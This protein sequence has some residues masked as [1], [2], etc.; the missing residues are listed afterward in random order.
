[1]VPMAP[2]TSS[3][4]C[5]VCSVAIREIHLGLEA[6]R[7]CALF[8]KR[9]K[10]TRR[11]Y[12]CR[13]GT[14]KCV[15]RKHA[16]FSC[17]K[18]R[19]DRCIAIGMEN[20]YGIVEG[21]VREENEGQQESILD[22]IQE[23]Y[24]RLMKRII[25]AER[26]IA[27]IHKLPRANTD[28]ELY[29]TTAKFYYDTYPITLHE[30]CN[31]VKCIIPA[32]EHFSEDIK[33]GI[34]KSLL[35]KFY[36]L[37]TCFRT[38]KI[39]LKTG[40]CMATAISCFDID[41]SDQWMD[42]S[43]ALGRNKSLWSSLEAHAR[44]FLEILYKVLK[45][46]E[47]TDREFHALIAIAFCELDTTIHLPDKIQCLFDNVRTKALSELQEYYKDRL[48]LVDYSSR[49][50]NLL[51]LTTAISEIHIISG[52]NQLLYSTLFDIRSE[53]QMIRDVL[54]ASCPQNKV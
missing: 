8:F 26:R 42:E 17:K 28:Q 34:L 12:M 27:E 49:M 5:L 45:T 24:E 51:S 52:K 1:I 13:L 46:D 54:T 40:K 50:G 32:F 35:G 47:I 11:V 20:A 41:K 22:K 39:Y 18:C 44:D 29:F 43:E 30:L 38:S 3:H 36:A 9:T 16:M 7:A 15:F 23:E 2:S 21:P 48:K 4:N 33:F 19:F 6:C 31:F 25:E 14:G 37:N 10:L 53:D